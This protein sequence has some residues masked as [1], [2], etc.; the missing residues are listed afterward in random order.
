MKIQRNVS[1]L[2][3]TLIQCVKRIQSQIIDAH[4]V[5]IRLFETGREHNRHE[6]LINKGKT[7][8]II[9]NHLYNLENDPPL[10]AMA[11]DYVYYDKKWSW[12]LRDGTT[13]AWY[14]LF[15]NLVLDV[16]PELKWGGYNR[17][18]INFC[19]FELLK[20]AIIAKLDEIPCVMPL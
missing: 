5:P 11:V 3:P 18:S 10:Y 6:M 17:K 2:H 8:N 14:I 19:H 12:N 13:N 4:N 1:M 9:S 7:K 20:T 15:A 16:C